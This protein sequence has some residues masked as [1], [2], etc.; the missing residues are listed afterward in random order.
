MSELCQLCVSKDGSVRE[1]HIRIGGKEVL[2]SQKTIKE[3]FGGESLLCAVT[4]S[5]APAP[6]LLSPSDHMHL[7][8]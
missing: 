7:P 1:L 2:T 5:S 3:N 8:F 6:A 4:L